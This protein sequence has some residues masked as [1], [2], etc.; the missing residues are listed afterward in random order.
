MGRLIA[1]ERHV[2]PARFLLLFGAGRLFGLSLLNWVDVDKLKLEDEIRVR[3]DDSASTARAVSIFA[4]AVHLR[5]LAL[6]QMSECFLPAA[7]DIS[8]AYLESKWTIPFVAGIKLLAIEEFSSVVHGHFV[9]SYR[10][11][12]IRTYFVL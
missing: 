10:L 9:A 2:S 1:R 7:N 3:R 5:L 4:G 12:C 6:S 11:S 8:L